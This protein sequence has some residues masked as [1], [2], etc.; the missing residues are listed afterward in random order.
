MKEYSMK[1]GTVNTSGIT[2]KKY[3][4]G[5]RPPVKGDGPEDVGYSKRSSG[6]HKNRVLEVGCGTGLFTK[7]LAGTD[8]AIVAID[9]SER[10]ILKAKAESL[11]RERSFHRR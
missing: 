3:G 5:P 7:E 4:T 8:N 1:Y 6:N 9:I 10:L 11:I 2:V